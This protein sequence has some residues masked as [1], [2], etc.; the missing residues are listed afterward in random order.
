[1]TSF[2]FST[3]TLK[4]TIDDDND[5]NEIV[6]IK[7]QCAAYEV[8]CFGASTLLSLK[9]G[10]DCITLELTSLC[11]IQMVHASQNRKSM[12]E[13]VNLPVTN[14]EKMNHFRFVVRINTVSVCKSSPPV[15][16]DSK[17]NLKELYT[18]NFFVVVVQCWCACRVSCLSEFFSCVWWWCVS[19]HCRVGF[20]LH[21][22]TTSS[23]T[24]TCNRFYTS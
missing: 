15:N 4:W 12:I 22:Q 16:T 7:I 1:M 10:V 23:C 8:A 3:W 24:T 9:V 18:L 21:W 11:I 19:N 17:W 6:S 2:V 13:Y 14:A 5:K 20:A